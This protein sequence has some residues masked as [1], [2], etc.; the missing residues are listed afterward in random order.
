MNSVQFPCFKCATFEAFLLKVW[1]YG[2][3]SGFLRKGSSVFE[4]FIAPGN[5]TVNPQEL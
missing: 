5:G 2:T 1:L 3:F 4:V